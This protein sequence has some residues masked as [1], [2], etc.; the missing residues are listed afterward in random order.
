[1]TTA[2]ASL[3]LPAWKR[4]TW[5]RPEWWSLC[6]CAAAWALMLWRANP[7]APGAHAHH[8]HAH[9]D[10]EMGAAGAAG[11]QAVWAADACWWLVMVAAMMFPM[12][13]DPVR[14]TAERSLWRRRHRAIAGFL[15]GYVGTWMAFGVAASMIVAALGAEEWRPAGVAAAAGFGIALLWQ[16]T[17]VKRRAALACHRTMPLAPTG[18]RADRDCLRYGWVVGRSCLLSCWALM[19]A[20]LL[21]GHGMGAMVGV[22]AISWAERN[23]ARPRQRLLCAAIAALAAYSILAAA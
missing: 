20:C 9:Q 18:W 16:V 2:A 6:L 21:A 1:M 4:L 10:M 22:T 15:V 11:A 12:V 3:R 17:P 23:R 14:T 8:M 19:L 7:F 5:P 13:L